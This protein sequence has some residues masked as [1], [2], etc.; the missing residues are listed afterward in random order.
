MAKKKVFE[1]YREKVNERIIRWPL[2]NVL[3]LHPGGSYSRRPAL[4]SIIT[5]IFQFVLPL[6][7]SNLFCV[8]SVSL[9]YIHILS[10]IPSSI[11][12]VL[13]C[14]LFSVTNI[15]ISVLCYLVHIFFSI[16]G[17]ACAVLFISAQKLVFNQSK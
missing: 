5:M 8:C 4:C 16:V 3:A 1:S 9:E 11:I 13:P 7:K 10:I 6:D 15:N 17:A 2:I 12:L 14:K